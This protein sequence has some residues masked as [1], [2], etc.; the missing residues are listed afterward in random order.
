MHYRASIYNSFYHK[1]KEEGYEFHVASNEYQDVDFPLRFVRHDLPFSTAKYAKLIRELKPDVVINFLHLKDKLIIPL[2]IYCRLKGIPMI[3]WNHG[4]NLKDA[5]NKWKNLI[6]H[7][8]HSISNA[9]I[10]YTPDQLKYILRRNLKKTFIA[11]NTLSFESSDVFRHSLRRPKEIKAQ[12]GI[13]EKYVLLYISRILPYKG[14]DILLPLFANLKDLALV[15]VGEGINDNQMQIVESTPNYYYLGEKYGKDVDEIY[16]IG[17]MFSTPGH[18]G[19]ALNQAMYWGLPVL[20]LNRK[21]APE[22]YYMKNGENGFVLNNS[23][24]LRDKVLELCDNPTLLAKI[25]ANARK[26]YET[27]MSLDNMYEGFLKAINYVKK[28]EHA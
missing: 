14:L 25:S 18:I 16:S 24:E 17:D 7:F 3:Y 5:D 27:K 13:K 26:T 4:V 21:H 11:F 12:Y 8:I 23:E 20:V 1:W 28:R 10:L 2:T 22:I 15:I 9:I 19:L 6:F